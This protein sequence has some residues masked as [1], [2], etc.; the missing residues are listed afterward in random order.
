M[1]WDAARLANRLRQRHLVLLENIAR[2]G[3]LTRVA[4][5]T[6]ISQPAATKALAELEAIFGAPL[7]LRTGRGMQPT[8]LGEL[9]L[10]RARRMQSDLDLWAREVEALH[11]GRAAHLHVGVVPYVSSALLTAAIGRLHQRHGVT[12][13]LH[14]ATTDHLVP[15][16][17]RHELDCVISRA[18]STVAQ[19]DLDHRVLYRQR[20]RVIAHSRL[21]QRLARRAPDWA[22]LAGMD[23][24]LPA[25]NTPTRQLIVE[26]FI[27]AGLRSPSPVLEAY[28]TDVIEGMLSAN[29]A[30][31]SVVPEDIARE[32]CQRGKLGMV[33]WDFGWELPP[34]NL[35]RRRREQALAAEERFSDILLELCADL[36][37]DARPRA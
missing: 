16:L 9:A 17:R 33:P 4:A 11:D 25:V 34:I 8:P 10:V 36:G 13:T 18:T 28:S 31:V 12:L 6:G 35:I 23:W 29:P 27:R 24:V 20:P 22:Q 15:M 21:A 2:H 26:H 3:T 37:Q 7:F 32:L 30:L 5:A 14:R 19:D 1:T